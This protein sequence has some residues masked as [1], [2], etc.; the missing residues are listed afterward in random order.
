MLTVG[1]RVARDPLL[2][3]TSTVRYGTVVQAYRGMPSCNAPGVQLFAV[4]W[5]D[6]GE[7][8]HGYMEHG[9]RILPES[10]KEELPKTF[11]VHNPPI[12]LRRRTE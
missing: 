5:D 8:I 2:G 3:W 9:L 6:T 11:T 10:R 4:R 7:T 1:D 12:R